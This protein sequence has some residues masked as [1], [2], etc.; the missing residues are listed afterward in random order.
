MGIVGINQIG[1]DA[2]NESIKEGRD[3]PW[4]QDN[5]AVNVWADWGI[6]YR[7]VLL[8]DGDRRAVHV[9]N[10]S[11]EGLQND[12]NYCNLA[13]IFFDIDDGA[14]VEDIRTAVDDGDYDGFCPPGLI[15]EAEL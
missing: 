10:L 5:E 13:Q 11:N 4:V 7:D 9:S 2:G 12:V 3:A 14:S 6:N 15:W 1:Y 8:L